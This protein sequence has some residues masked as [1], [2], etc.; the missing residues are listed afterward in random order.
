MDPIKLISYIIKELRRS[1]RVL[2]KGISRKQVLLV[3]IKRKGTQNP[4]DK[5]FAFSPREFLFK[6]K[7]T[8]VKNPSSSYGNWH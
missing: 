8:R 4:D 2:K 3:S 7:M 6:Y 1:E 5:S